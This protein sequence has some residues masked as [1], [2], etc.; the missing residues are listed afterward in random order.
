MMLLVSE[1]LQYT[2]VTGRFYGRTDPEAGHIKAELW[3]CGLGRLTNSSEPRG[4]E[5]V[6]RLSLGKREGSFTAR[7]MR[8]HPYSPSL[9]FFLLDPL[10]LAPLLWSDPVTSTWFY[11]MPVLGPLS[12]GSFQH[13]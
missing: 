2:S 3:S 7:P 8:S 4:K 11:P 1:L 12:S 13:S 5:Y 10:R 9:H 6:A